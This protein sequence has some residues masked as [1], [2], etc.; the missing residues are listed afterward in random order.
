VFGMRLS[1]KTARAICRA[2]VH[3]ISK[4]SRPKQARGKTACG[5]PLSPAMRLAISVE[6]LPPAYQV[7]KCCSVSDNCQDT[8]PCSSL[9]EID[10]QP[11]TNW[12]TV[13]YGFLSTA[14][15][16]RNHKP[17]EIVAKLRQVDVLIS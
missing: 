11:R 4:V 8:N 16:R 5:S 14:M 17:A 10:H 3:S 1:L 15:P 6:S 7:Q 2:C 12:S 13:S 9:P